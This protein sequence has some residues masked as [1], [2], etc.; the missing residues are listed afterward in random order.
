M[1][2][3]HE[4][5]H[6][7]GDEVA[8]AYGAL[9]DAVEPSVDV[10]S[11]L[12]TLHSRVGRRA[13]PRA[14]TAIGAVAAAAVLVVTGAIVTRSEVP[15]AVQGPADGAPGSVTSSTVSEPSEHPGCDE[16]AVHLYLEPWA[17][18]EQVDAVRSRI[19]EIDPGSEWTYVDRDATYDEFRRLF[20]EQ[21]DFVD[22]MEPGDLPTSFRRAV[23]G[24]V[25]S[26]P[27]VQ[28]NGLDGVLRS[29]PVAG[30]LGCPDAT[31]I[32]G[33]NATTTTSPPAP[34]G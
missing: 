14:I 24:D 5:H 33:P 27:V 30:G 17:T 28:L 16:P 4:F 18:D 26:I 12:S 20:A 3:D 10:D 31:E 9:R 23:T 25:A 34:G 22:A 19:Q 21:P 32:I 2:N 1:T 8:A 7:D 29:E 6:S 11:S 13:V 15:P